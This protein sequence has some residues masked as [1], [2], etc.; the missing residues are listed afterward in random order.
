MVAITINIT[1]LDVVEGRLGL[2]GL[3]R[4]NLSENGCTNLVP[5]ELENLAVDLEADVVRIRVS[6]PQIKVQCFQ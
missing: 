4:A 1:V 5:R 2:I 3:A 6:G